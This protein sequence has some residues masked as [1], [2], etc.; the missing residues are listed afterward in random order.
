MCERHKI[1]YIVSQK[2]LLLILS[3]NYTCQA[4]GSMYPEGTNIT[5]NARGKSY[6]ILN[7]LRNIQKYCN[8]KYDI[9]LPTTHHP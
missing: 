1:V 4:E 2:A 8:G 9:S 7:S 5:V 3:D 6:I